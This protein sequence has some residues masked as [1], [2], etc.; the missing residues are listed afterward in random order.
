ML[1]DL[2]VARSQGKAKK[3]FRGKPPATPLKDDGWPSFWTQ[4]AEDAFVTLKKLAVDCIPLYFPD[5]EG[6]SNGSNPMM[7]P[8]LV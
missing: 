2:H 3:G 1:S 8:S 7:R 5:Y 4:E 6:A